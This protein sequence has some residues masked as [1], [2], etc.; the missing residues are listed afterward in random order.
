MKIN[1]YQTALD[2]LYSFVDYS[3]ERS[4][5]YS[6]EAFDLGR[7]A[8]LLARL[9]EPHLRYP[10]LHIAGTK[11]KGSVAAL[12]A[13]CLAHAGYRTGLYT[14]PHLVDF[15][16]RIRING[17]PIPPADVAGLTSDLAAHAAGVPGLTTF[18]LVTALGFMY[19]AHQQVEAAVIEVGLGGRLDAT[20]LV[21]P[22]VTAITSISFDHTHLLGNTLGA[23]AGEKAGILKPGVPLVVAPQ[24]EEARRV[25]LVRAAEVGAPVTEI[26]VDWIVEPEAQ[27]VS[28]QS[29]RLYRTGD[30]RSPV[31]LRMPL[32]GRH[33]L[34]NAAVAYAALDLAGDR[35]LPL[36]DRALREG[37]SEV[38]WPGRFQILR[39]DP[40]LVV[41]AAHNQRLGP[42]ACGNGGFR[43]P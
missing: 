25:I 4:D 1:S 31:R 19:F 21:Q 27:D 12:M 37:F 9:S 6:A 26:G 14:S 32:L 39:H 41:D 24:P 23:I 22:L 34:D 8:D 17:S 3:R 2:Y 16:E 18:E 5:R 38:D 33:Q 29:L 15:T 42:P 40:S 28:G 7:M 43:L 35:G 11:G 20:N 30:G 13:S 36:S 10:T